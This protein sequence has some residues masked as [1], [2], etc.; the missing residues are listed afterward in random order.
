MG[1]R[2]NDDTDDGY[3]KKSLCSGRAK[4]VG[5]RPRRAQLRC[6]DGTVPPGPP[7][8]KHCIVLFAG[9]FLP[10]SLLP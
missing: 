10:L 4:G 2:A 6:T 3:A 8:T 9:L 5:G 7:S 1:M